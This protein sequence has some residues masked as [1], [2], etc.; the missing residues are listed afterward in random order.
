MWG[1]YNLSLHDK[2]VTAMGILSFYPTSRLAPYR[3]APQSE[4]E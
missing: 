1:T 4:L 2:Q 3:L